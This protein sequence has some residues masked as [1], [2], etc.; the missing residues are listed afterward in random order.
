MGLCLV[1]KIWEKEGIEGLKNKPRTEVDHH[2]SYHRRSYLQ[3]KNNIKGKQSWL[4]HKTSR[5]VNHIKKSG[6]KYHHTHIYR[7]LRKWRFRQKV[8]RKVHVNIQHSRKRK[9]ISKKD[10]E[11]IFV[12]KHQ[13]E[14]Q[15]SFTII[16]T[17]TNHSFFMILFCKKGFWI[18]E[19]KR[20]IVRVTD[21]HKHSCILVS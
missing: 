9:W 7:I 18:D 14:Q 2:L 15:E 19:S 12:D 16:S 13:Q 20:P 11:Q 21:S 5:R 4:D 8:P 1:K 10:T 6:I 3:H 17:W